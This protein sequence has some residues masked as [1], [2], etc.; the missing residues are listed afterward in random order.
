MSEICDGVTFLGTVNRVGSAASGGFK[1]VI[2][3]PEV[4][5]DAASK[6][7]RDYRDKVVS[8]AIVIAP[9]G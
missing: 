8:V 4:E 3:V 2:D 1:L 9:Q 7:M 5:A 6:L